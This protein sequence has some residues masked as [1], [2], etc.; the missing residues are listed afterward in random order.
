MRIIAN[1]LIF[2]FVLNVPL[3]AYADQFYMTVNYACD[4]NPSML[5]ISFNGAW[6]SK[7]EA[8]GAVLKNGWRTED[9]VAFDLD[10]NDK[11]VIHELHKSATCRLKGQ[12]YK[13][14][15]SPAVPPG[16]YPDGYCGARMGALV[17]VLLKN[18]LLVSRSVDGC[19]ET[20]MVT[21]EIIIR[22]DKLPT[23]KEVEGRT[24]YDT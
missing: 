12:E 14:I 24:F 11:Y 10:K 19:T 9:L 4:S 22:P 16:Y 20:G 5:R 13:I 8:L 18:K 21:T 3:Q 7:G 17:R 1:C 23:Y 15:I 2:G 6:N